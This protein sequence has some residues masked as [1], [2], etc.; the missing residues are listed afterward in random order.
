MHSRI[1]SPVGQEDEKQI[2]GRIDPELGSSKAGMPICGV[3]D[4]RPEQTGL[5]EVLLWSVPSQ[6]AGT[7]VCTPG[8]EAANGGGAP[9]LSFGAAAL[10]HPPLGVAGQ[11][12]TSRENPRVARRT[13]EDGG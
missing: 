12:Q 7:A 1:E 5:V 10:S 9:P 4:Q 13:S 11:V 2:P 6:Q 3:A 8:E